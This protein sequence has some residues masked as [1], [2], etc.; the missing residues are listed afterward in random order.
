M[1]IVN[2]VSGL[3]DEM[4]EWRQW[5]H[6]NPELCIN[7][8]KTAAYVAER[9]REIGV[10]ELHEGIAK[11]GMIAII[12][13]HGA[14]PCI[15]LRADMDALPIEEATGLPY[16]SQTAGQMHACGHDGHMAMLL[17]AAKYLV[18]T[19]RF[20]GRVALIFQPA[21]ETIGG[22]NLMIEEGIFER[23]GIAQVFAIH[24]NPTLPLGH[25]EIAAGPYMAAVD[26]F[27]ITLTG[28]GGHAAY[29]HLATDALLA[30]AHA[31]T[32]LQ[33]IPARD[34]VGAEAFVLTVTGFQSGGEATNIMANAAHIEGTVRA[35]SAEARDMAEQRIRAIVE[36]QATTFGVKAEVRYP[37]S[38]P[39]TINHV[40][41][42]HFAVQTALEISGRDAVDP[43][44]LPQLAAEDFGYMLEVC[45]GAYAMIGQG[46][47]PGLH[48]PGFDFNDALAPIGASYLVRLVE[49]AQPLNEIGSSYA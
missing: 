1:P 17:G 44:P 46:R 29:P 31:V 38:Y 39:P 37:R 21:E 19:R 49:R 12:N 15:G 11:T 34:R 35:Y 3:A 22:A 27:F 28:S 36:G 14:G 43:N 32:A 10:D 42:A 6:R 30:G 26:E 24:T 2:R 9:L 8:P 16:A 18:E 25:F 45:P 4:T 5:L 13:G 48:E 23:F 7:L 33:S 41:Q 47:G 40:E 20:S